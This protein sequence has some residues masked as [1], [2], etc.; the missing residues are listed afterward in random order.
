VF[1]ASRG[2]K[3]EIK[4]KGRKEEVVGGRVWALS[5]I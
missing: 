2:K 4:E 1:L 5:I 3:G